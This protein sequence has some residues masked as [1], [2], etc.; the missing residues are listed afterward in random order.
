[1]LALEQI[2]QDRP[3]DGAP[4]RRRVLRLP[5][6]PPGQLAVLLAALVMLCLATGVAAV[7]DVQHRRGVLVDLAERSSPLADAA[8]QIYQALSDADATANSMFLAGDQV[9]AELRE[10]YRLDIIKAAAALSTAAA[11][12]SDSATASTVAELTAQLTAYAGLVETAQANN[13]QGH[14]V[15]SNYL[16]EASALAQGRLLPAAD[17]IYDDERARLVAAQ[18]RAGS[19]GWVP[20]T[21]SAL[22]LAVLFGGQLY[23]RR[24]TRRT[25]N[26]GLLVATGA[27]LV[28]IGWFALASL[29]AARH[30]DAGRRDGTAQMEAIAD[31]R[32]TALTARSAETLILIARGDDRSYEDDFDQASQRLNGDATAPGSLTVVRDRASQPETR[33]AVDAAIAI[34]RHWHELHQKLREY[35][36]NGDISDNQCAVWLATGVDTRDAR[37]SAEPLPCHGSPSVAGNDPTAVLAGRL[38]QDLDAAFGQ[39]RARFESEVSSAR[40]ALNGVDAIVAALLLLAA[41]GAGL[42]IA[43]RLREYR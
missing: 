43:P 42:G 35:D 37:A 27:I 2:Q 4:L 9:P 38:D 22:T 16:Q 12:A 21:S 10:R 3:A 18:D 39:A 17:Q 23:L 8:V 30:S 36:D 25:L 14:A 11:G 13:R 24:T 32:I 7:V 26:L 15:G 5:K 28:A 29:S 31:A 1:M 34:W 41:L 40:S 6:T 19:V 33:A 20:L